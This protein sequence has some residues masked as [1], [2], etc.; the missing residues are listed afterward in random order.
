MVRHTGEDFIDEE[1]VA[2][3]TMSPLQSF[4]IFGSKLYTPQP[5]RLSTDDDSSFS[6]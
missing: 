1:C 5:D 6:E 4:G 3:T 2:I